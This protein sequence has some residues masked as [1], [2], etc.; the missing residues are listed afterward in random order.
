MDACFAATWLDKWMRWLKLW[1]KTLGEWEKYWIYFYI[2]G[3][4]L[5]FEKNIK[6][7]ELE[8]PLKYHSSVAFFFFSCGSAYLFQMSWKQDPNLFQSLKCRWPFSPHLYSSWAPCPWKLVGNQQTQLW[9]QES[10]P[11]SSLFRRASQGHV[12]LPL[13]D[14]DLD[15]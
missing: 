13:Q 2:V 5:R 4:G 1:I 3:G 12:R 10:T 11:A 15:R 6:I 7:W 9:N 14:N 8:I